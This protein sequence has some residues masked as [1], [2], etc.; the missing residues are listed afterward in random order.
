MKFISR[1]INLRVVLRPGIPGEPMV[2]RSPIPGLYVKFEDGVANVT[3]AESIKLMLL[4]M[5]GFGVDYVAADDEEAKRFTR[6]SESEPEHDV[7]SIEY[8]HVGKN[9]NPKG[10]FTL[11]AELKDYIEKAAAKRAAEIAKPLALEL[12]KE[13]MVSKAESEAPAKVVEKPAIK[14]IDVQVPEPIEEED[15]IEVQIPESEGDGGVDMSVG[16]PDFK[17]E[18]ETLKE[19]AKISKPARKTAVK[20]A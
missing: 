15:G 5:K 6:L 7:Y 17:P 14:K 13:M 9:M 3:D 16:N 20:K 12:L 10:Q 1:N 4:P 11:P 8:G 19:D 18:D 2:G